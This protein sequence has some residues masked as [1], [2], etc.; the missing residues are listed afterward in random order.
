MIME[1]E[2]TK[3]IAEKIEEFAKTYLDTGDPAN[4]IEGM[5]VYVEHVNAHLWKENNRL[6]NMA[7]ARLQAYEKQ[8]EK[9]LQETENSKLAELGKTRDDYEK[10]VKDLDDDLTAMKNS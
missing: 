10:L 8:V 5:E 3:Q 2:T 7:D 6:F 9:A 1:H 4:L